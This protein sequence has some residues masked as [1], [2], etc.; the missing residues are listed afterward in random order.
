VF[1]IPGTERG[2]RV[3]WRVLAQSVGAVEGTR[4]GHHSSLVDVAVCLPRVNAA[5]QSD[6]WAVGQYTLG[7]IDRV[8]L[9]HWDGLVWT[10]Y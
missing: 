4:H 6:V 8:L 1:E 9:E 3:Y 2:W 7:G 10:V 5:S